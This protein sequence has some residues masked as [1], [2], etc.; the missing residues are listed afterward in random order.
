LPSGGFL[1]WRNRLC[2]VINAKDEQVLLHQPSPPA[3]R[4][5]RFSISNNPVG[6]YGENTVTRVLAADARG[7]VYSLKL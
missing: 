2:A 3:I 1:Y 4:S 5:S 7:L 6:P